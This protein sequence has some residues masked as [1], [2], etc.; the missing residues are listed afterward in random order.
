MYRSL[1]YQN[2]IMTT[3]YSS[4]Y[5]YSIEKINYFASFGII[6]QSK[7]VDQYYVDYSQYY[8]ASGTSSG[9]QILI[10]RKSPS[11]L[12][13]SNSETSDPDREIGEMQAGWEILLGL[14]ILIFISSSMGVFL[15]KKR[16]K[17]LS[18]FLL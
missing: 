18:A 14:G 7:R 11:V 10:A 17:I 16:T 9:E 6:T 3:Y 12:Q 15:K 1:A 5:Q 2:R 4:D 13:Q 8:A